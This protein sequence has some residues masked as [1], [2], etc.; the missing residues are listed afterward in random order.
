MNLSD[1]HKFLEKLKRVSKY[2]EILE[3]GSMSKQYVFFFSNFY[4]Q[5]VRVQIQ[6]KQNGI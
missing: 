4:F 3:T 2:K 1:L 5:L 6:R